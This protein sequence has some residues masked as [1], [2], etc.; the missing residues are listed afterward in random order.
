MLDALPR[1]TSAIG[2]VR[3]VDLSWLHRAEVKLANLTKPP[4]SLGRLE[5]LAARLCAIQET[6]SPRAAARRIVVF[7]ADH[8]VAAEGVSAYPS[9]VT[10]QMVEGFLRG[11]AAINALVR[12][13]TSE[14][15]RNP[16]PNMEAL[17]RG[18]A[19]AMGIEEGRLDVYSRAE[20]RSVLAI[21][22]A[23][24]PD[25]YPVCR[26]MSATAKRAECCSSTSAIRRTRR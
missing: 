11:G 13:P 8:G 10:A 6:V 17:A 12:D 7:A 3:P 15:E 14:I 26:F 16:V 9:A 4:N 19:S 20:L 23:R 21:L 24:F 1:L 2:A 18:I 25:L 22:E 5:W